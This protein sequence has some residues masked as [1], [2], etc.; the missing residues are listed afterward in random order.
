MVCEEFG[1]IGS[2]QVISCGCAI[3]AVPAKRPFKETDVV[4]QQKAR[5]NISDADA[6]ELHSQEVRAGNEETGKDPIGDAYVPADPR[7]PEAGDVD[8]AD[9]ASADATGQGGDATEAGKREG[10]PWS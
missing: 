4:N 2:Q 6:K 8:P 10:Q 7:T 3:Q 5:Q 9:T 1:Y